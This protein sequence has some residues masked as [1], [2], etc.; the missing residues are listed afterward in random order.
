MKP[1]LAAERPWAFRTSQNLSFLFGKRGLITV[2]LEIMHG[3]P[4]HRAAATLN[5]SHACSY[6]LFLTQGQGA[7]VP[8]CPP[9]RPTDFEIQILKE[10]QLLLAMATWV[11]EP[12]QDPLPPS[13]SHIL[14][15]PQ[16]EREYLPRRDTGKH[17]ADVSP[18]HPRDCFP[19]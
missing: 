5:T 10:S 7:S 2:V 4:Q 15:H 6:L 17:L 8:L 16:A 13:S 14:L 9:R 3:K 19:S 11:A 1:I 18:G 12:G